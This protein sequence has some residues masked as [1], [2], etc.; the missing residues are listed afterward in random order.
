M[1]P[2][3]DPDPR[4]SEQELLAMWG[5]HIGSEFPSKYTIKEELQARVQLHF[6]GEENERAG[7]HPEFAEYR[8]KNAERLFEILRTADLRA[9]RLLVDVN[10]LECRLLRL[11]GK[12]EECRQLC[13][14]MPVY[15]WDY[16]M[17]QEYIWATKRDDYPHQRFRVF[18][19]QDDK[20]MAERFV[21]AALNTYE[22]DLESWTAR[23]EEETKPPPLTDWQ[24]KLLV[25]YSFWLSCLIAA[26]SGIFVA[27]SSAGPIIG[28][29]AAILVYLVSHATLA[30]LFACF[31]I[32][33]KSRA[34]RIKEWETA[35][36]R[37]VCRISINP[38]AAF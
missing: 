34:E 3:T 2:D 37:P 17:L 12:F 24:Y 5:E 14:S 28:T 7:Q 23:R 35:N 25:D 21:A 30:L 18:K 10:H 19:D 26:A 33:G 13:Q 36:P 32:K 6:R 29:I 4:Q 20:A 15:S 11:V 22:S 38:N 31:G 8:A 1:L 9:A 16:E 27:T